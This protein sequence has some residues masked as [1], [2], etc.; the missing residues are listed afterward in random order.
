MI[1][2][3]DRFLSNSGRSMKRSA[4]REILK[5]LQ[6]PDMISFAGGLPAPETFP[7]EDLKEIALEVLEKD[8]ANALQYSTT[9]G[10]TLLRRMLA[11]KHKREGVNITADNIIITTGSQQ[12]LDLILQQSTSIFFYF[13]LSSKENIKKAYWLALLAQG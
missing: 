5:H 3:S 6:N 13:E 2:S 7:V 9:E 1:T 12:A 11:E 4:I 8:G 10:D